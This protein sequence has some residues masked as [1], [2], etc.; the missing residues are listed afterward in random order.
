MN[1]LE[2]RRVV[3]SFAGGPPLP[4]QFALSGTGEPFELYLRAAAPARG[5]APQVRF[6]PFITLAQ[7]LLPRPDSAGTEEVLLLPSDIA[8]ETGERSA[9]PGVV[10]AQQEPAQ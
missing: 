9:V 1:F 4:L 10:G 7:A 3:S 8:P 6:L 5:R 2:A